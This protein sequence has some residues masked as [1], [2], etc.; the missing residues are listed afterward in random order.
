MNHVVSTEANDS[1]FRFDSAILTVSKNK[2]HDGVNEMSSKV[3]NRLN[4][5]LLVGR[6]EDGKLRTWFKAVR[7]SM[8]AGFI[9]DAPADLESPRDDYKGRK[10]ANSST[11]L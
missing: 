5:G 6:K 2:D 3:N 10:E 11:E 1:N 9:M 8:Q 7:L 4:T